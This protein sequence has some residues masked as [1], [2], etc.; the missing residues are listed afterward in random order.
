VLPLLDQLLVL[1]LLLLVQL[2]VLPLLLLVQLLVLPLLLL[3][4]QLLV[5]LLLLVLL[6]LPV[7]GQVLPSI[8]VAT[9]KF[10]ACLSYLTCLRWPL[11]VHILF[12]LL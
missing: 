1:P 4:V 7:L 3:L 10:S 6:P 2:L 9:V 5:L 11:L 8:S 12:D